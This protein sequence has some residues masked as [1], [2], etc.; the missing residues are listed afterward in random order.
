MLPSSSSLWLMSALEHIDDKIWLRENLD[1]AFFYLPDHLINPFEVLAGS[2]VLD[3]IVP[4]GLDVGRYTP[5]KRLL[6]LALESFESLEPPI[7][8]KDY[9]PKS[10]G[11][12][13]AEQNSTEYYRIK[14]NLAE[15]YL[16]L[17]E[18]RDSRDLIYELLEILDSVDGINQLDTYCLILKFFGYGNHMV[19][20]FDVVHE[21]TE[22]AV[23]RYPQR[24]LDLYIAIAYYHYS[25]GDPDKVKNMLEKILRVMAEEVQVASIDMI[26]VN[27]ISAEQNYFL[28]VVY[29]DL[30][31][32]DLA[33]KYLER[34][35]EQYS[36]L[37]NPI[38]NMLMLFEKA[39]LFRF[40]GQTD[41]AEQWIK[42]AYDEYYKL[43][44]PQSFHLA[45]LNHTYG[46]IY[47][48]LGEFETARNL[49]EQTLPEWQKADH[50]YHTALTYN[51]IGYCLYEMGQI[52]DAMEHYGIA[53]AKCSVLSEVYARSLMQVIDK[54]IENAKNHF[55]DS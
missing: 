1:N 30:Q 17:R 15:V 32:F 44:E 48:D 16:T 14:L 8:E 25:Q 36:R 51:A 28:A 34:A 41:A 24:R 50:K 13:F 2:A 33:S 7:G 5:L 45:M 27:R 4:I 55:I 18:L 38:R 23:K 6:L 21:A 22:L 20:D 11:E 43:A 10:D 42:L 12:T 19:L 29:R 46:L 53:K 3:A 40:L 31:E 37:E 49:F 35:S 9:F 54:N 47:V 52:D 26:D 39:V